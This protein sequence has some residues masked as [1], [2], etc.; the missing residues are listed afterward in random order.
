MKHV[1]IL[2]AGASR[3][4]GGPLMSDLLDRAE[5][6][7]RNR[8]IDEYASD[9]VFRGLEELQIAHS[10]AALDINN[11]ESVMAA[12]EMA[13]LFGRLGKLTPKD[14]S[15]LPRAITTVVAQ[16]VEELVEF[17]IQ[18]AGVEAPYSYLSLKKLL[19]QWDLHREQVALVTF[20]YD[21]ALDVLLN[22]LA[23]TPDYSLEDTFGSGVPLLKLHGSLGWTTKAGDGGG[24]DSPV[25]IPLNLRPHIEKHSDQIE[26]PPGQG[27]PFR[28]RPFLKQR[29]LSGLPVIVPPTW[30][31]ENFYKSIRNVWRRAAAN[32]GRRR[33]SMSSGT[34]SRRWTTSFVSC[35]PLV[36]SAQH[37]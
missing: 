36:R 8:K 1:F 35:T 24:Q 28:V 13:A 2:G 3:E 11:V 27:H 12:F 37:D 4:A 6:L 19:K 5:R 16:T 26:F 20:N 17:Q 7:S 29:G 21:L 33:I 31:K 18:S 14:V 32:S 15:E 34:L 30:A 10:K 23:F 25:I 22:N 9:L